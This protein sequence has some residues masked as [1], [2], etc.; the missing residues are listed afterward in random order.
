MQYNT[1]LS[2]IEYTSLKHG[3]N[4]YRNLQSITESTFVVCTQDVTLEMV[5]REGPE[6]QMC[7]DDDVCV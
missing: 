5:K 6:E 1:R 2:R 7:V 4:T 3:I